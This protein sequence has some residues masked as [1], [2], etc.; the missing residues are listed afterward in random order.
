M[1]PASDPVN[2][3]QAKRHAAGDPASNPFGGMEMPMIKLRSFTYALFMVN[4]V[5]ENPR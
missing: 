1:G 4:I 5:I 3:S 2:L